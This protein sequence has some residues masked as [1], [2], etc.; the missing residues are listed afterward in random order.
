MIIAIDIETMGDAERVARLPEPEV[1]LGNIKDPAKIAEKIAA[2]KVKQ[3]ARA[4]LSP[5]TGRIIAIATAGEGSA[6]ESVCCPLSN[7]ETERELISGFF[8]LVAAP[9]MRIVTFNGSRFDLPFIYRRALMLGMHPRNYG[10]PPLSHLLKKY[11]NQ[12]HIDLMRVW[13]GS[14]SIADA[15][16]LA[17]VAAGLLG[18]TRSDEDYEKF[19]EMMQTMDGRQHIAEACL[20]HTRLTY[21]LYARMAGAMFA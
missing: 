14:D 4:G 7:D 10:A 17:E 20:H 15:D 21:Q 3:A 19:P 12:A 8:Q 18:E 1:A 13:A 11:D 9:E 16:S 6:T 5:L 2:A